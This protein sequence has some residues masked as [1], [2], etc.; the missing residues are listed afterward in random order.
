MRALTLFLLLLPPAF[1]AIGLGSPAPVCHILA[2]VGV[3]MALLFLGI[4]LHARPTRFELTPGELRLVWPIRRRSIPRSRIAGARRISSAE[5][6][7]EFGFCARVG[8]GGLWGGFGWL[9]TS[10][11]GLLDL[12]VSRLDGWVLVERPAPDRPLLITPEDPDAF[13]AALG[14]G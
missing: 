1:L 10:R 13:L 2:V 5:L 6:R 14:A 3:A 11:A 9:W 7:R 4:W 12:Y 8:A